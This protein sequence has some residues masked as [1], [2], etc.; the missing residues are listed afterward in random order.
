MT[1][2]RCAA[3]GDGLLR[4]HVLV[5]VLLACTTAAA[6]ED[7]VEAPRGQMA[8]TYQYNEMRD[9]DSLEFVI[10]T[11]PIT[12]HL[13]DFAA[14][15][16]VNDRL[17]L[18]AGLPL[19]S[20]KA[21]A[22]SHDPLRII[23]PHPESDF[24][25]DG[26]F[27]TYFQDLRIGASYVVIT[28]PIIVEP[29]VEVSF[30]VGDYPFFA[31]S[32]VGQQLRKTEIGSTVAYRPP[33]LRWYFGL[34]AGYVSLPKTLGANV[35]TM[36]VDAET[37]YF[38]NSQLAVKLFLSS[39]NGHGISPPLA[40]DFTSELWYYHDRMIRHNYINAGLGVDWML[41]NRNVLS[42]DW[43]QMVHAEDVFKLR[44]GLNVTVSRSFGS[45]TP[46]S[47]HSRPRGAL[48][49]VGH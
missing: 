47:K 21:L 24:V 12:T 33:F 9:L 43:I 4:P 34:R 18:S 42:I 10:P 7:D 6:Q 40:P 28:D 14:S 45:A 31:V 22:P 35:D 3:R 16:A 39:K 13:V 37:V 8:F 23:P 32:A 26:H 20:R 49:S 17:T 5:A 2:R 38:V 44:K 19:I 27:H 48:S 29:Y 46:R 41:N 15:Y 30:P 11:S 1:A 36:R 25:D